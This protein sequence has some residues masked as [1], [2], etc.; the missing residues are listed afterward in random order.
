MLRATRALTGG[1]PHAV[2]STLTSAGTPWAMPPTLTSALTPWATSS[3]LTSTSTPTLT[4]R[5]TNSTP[6]KPPEA[7][8]PLAVLAAA[9]ARAR[10]RSKRG[11]VL[12]PGWELEFRDT[13]IPISRERLQGLLLREFH[14][15]GSARAS[16][17]A[18]AARLDAALSARY[19]RLHQHLQALYAPL[20]PDQ[21]TA[22]GVAPHLGV[23]GGSP[24]A[25]A[26]RV[27]RLV[28]ALEPLLREANF[29]RLPEAAIAFALLVQH[30]EDEAQVSVRLEDYELLQFWARGQR[31][32]PL[33][34]PESSTPRRWGRSSPAPQRHYFSRVVVVAQQRAGALELAEFRKVPLE[35]LELLLE[36]GRVRTPGLTRARLHLG[37]LGWAALLFLNLGLGLMADLKVG[38]TALLLGLGVLVTLRGTKAFAR[39]REAA[40]L[41][42]A[43][44]RYRRSA[45]QHEELLAAITRRAQDE[46]TKEALLAQ[47]F[48]PHCGGPKEPRA[49][50]EERL[51]TQV[52]EWLERNFGVPLAFNA[53]RAWE[54]LRAL[55]GHPKSEGGEP[56]NH[57]HTWGDPGSW[58][59]PPSEPPEPAGR[60]PKPGGD[61]KSLNTPP[62]TP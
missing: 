49:Q 13:F 38:A 12:P 55:G 48:L 21:E 44:S 62:S 52:E 58:G 42:L 54:W 23:A 3:T 11:P 59:H 8:A 31:R 5:A 9:V 18:V 26:R 61:L 35:A 27:R 50:I 10:G 20:D 34:T 16:F 14:S 47:T 7:S 29:Q 17:V 22:P 25:V 43:R 46:A 32:G 4:P 2:T 1:T 36:K 45:A 41:E 51:Q 57:E 40:A 33:P 53:P 56:Q 39:R 37:L 30:P 28:A 19:L 60:T 15:S 24:E 6:V